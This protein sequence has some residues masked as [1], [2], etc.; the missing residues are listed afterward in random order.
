MSETLNDRPLRADARRNR[1]RILE[2]A[3]EVFP[4][5]GM[6]AQMDDVAT[7]AGV[8]VGTVYRHFP[9]KESLLTAI[10]SE[11]FARITEFAQEALAEPAA[12]PAFVRM[13]E[14]GGELH[15]AD[16][17]LQQTLLIAPT[18]VWEA[19]KAEHPDLDVASAE[20]VRRAIAEGDMRADF[21][22]EEIGLVMCGVVATM[23][24]GFGDWRRH[25]EIVVDGIRAR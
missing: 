9:T 23:A 5:Q 2:A 16:A 14:R 8:G 18:T 25:L 11:K 15:A 6:Q 1:E 7:T 3:R 20:I 19:A 21:Q 22:A 24:R 4:V 10:V 12:W 17:A 13:L